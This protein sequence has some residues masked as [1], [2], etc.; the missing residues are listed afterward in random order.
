MHTHVLENLERSLV[1]RHH[2]VAAMKA[3]AI[4]QRGD[5]LRVCGQAL[6]QRRCL[7]SLERLLPDVD[8]AASSPVIR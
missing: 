4:G 6:G 8:R 2:G 3:V 5:Q 7:S 1:Q